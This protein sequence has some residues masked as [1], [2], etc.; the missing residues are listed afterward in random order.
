[1]IDAN[2]GFDCARTQFQTITS[3]IK[4]STANH[5]AVVVHQPFVTVKSTYGPNGMFSC[6]DPV[7]QN[8]GVHFVAQAHNHNYQV[9]KIGSVFDGFFGTGTHD[10]GSSMYS[11]GSTTFNIIPIKCITGTIE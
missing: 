11:C 7:F 8:N 3:K 10:T 5:K 6:F 1:V 9:G 4:S 2:S